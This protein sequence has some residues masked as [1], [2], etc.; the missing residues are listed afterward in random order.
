MS[1]VG[2]PGAGKSTVGVV[3]AKALG[4]GFVDS[5]LEIQRRAGATLQAILEAQGYLE[6]RR[7]EEAVLLDLPLR[8]VVLATGGS[9]VYSAASTARLSAAGPIVYLWADID[10]LERR[11]GANPLRGIASDPDTSFAE[12]YAERTPLYEACATMTVDV[13][14]RSAEQI[15]SELIER[16]D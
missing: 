7:Q 5:D 1:L 13:T 3:L 9:A 6:L 16:L 8:E 10:T 11:I 14:A 12:I 4:L 15:V 2:M